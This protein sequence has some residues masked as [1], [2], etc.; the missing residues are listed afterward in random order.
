MISLLIY[1]AVLAIV[2]IL[3]WWLLAQLPL[4]EPAGKIIRIGLVVIVAVVCIA[5]LLDFAGH[6]PALRMPR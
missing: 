3:V 5:I 1:L 2:V 4:P 6:V